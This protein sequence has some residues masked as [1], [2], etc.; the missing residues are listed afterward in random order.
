M[1]ALGDWAMRIA[2]VVIVL[3]LGAFF[4]VRAALLWYWR[5]DEQRAVLREI[6]DE[7][8]AARPA[9]AAVASPAATPAPDA[10]ADRL[11]RAVP[12]P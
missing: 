4:A 2:F 11:R 10:V 12:A 1:L 7:L 8:R 3:A 6:R 5:V 9:A